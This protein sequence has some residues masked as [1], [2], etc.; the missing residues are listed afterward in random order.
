MAQADIIDSE[1][2]VELLDGHIYTMSPIGSQHAACVRRLTRLFVQRVESQ[3]LVSVQNPIRLTSNSEPEPDISLL[4]PR[5][6]EYG[7][8]HPHPEEA[9][10]L[11]EVSGET[12]SFD[13]N[14]K[15]PLYAQAQIPEVWIVALDE[16]QIH[17]YRQ[18]KENHYAEHTTRERGEKL[19]V[20]ALPDIDSIQGAAVL[21]E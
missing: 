3:A 20:S 16:E 21:G 11:V 18:P 13:R 7:T 2:R 17:V 9:L 10:F 1:D 14:V 4:S 15:L 12:L 6:D 8:R 19:T 5:N